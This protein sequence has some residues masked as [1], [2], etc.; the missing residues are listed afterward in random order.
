MSF[1]IVQKQVCLF[2]IV[3]KHVCLF[4]IV[5][6][7]VCVF[8]IVQNQVFLFSIVQVKLVIVKDAIDD[9]CSFFVNHKGKTL[10]PL[11]RTAGSLLDKLGSAVCLN[12]PIINSFRRSAETK[13]QASASM[14]SSVEA[15]QLHSQ[16]VGLGHYDRS[17]DNIR[18]NFISQLN[19]IHR[20]S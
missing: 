7:H 2:S 1:Y 10:A 11:Q 13:V 16:K 12:N 20:D 18:T 8:S 4:S 19:I 5:Q 6:K 9:D 15:L 17:C 14:K 3:Q